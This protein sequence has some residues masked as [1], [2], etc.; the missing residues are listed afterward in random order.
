MLRNKQ[1]ENKSR[2]Q[3]NLAVRSWGQAKTMYERLTVQ[4]KSGALNGGD[5][6]PSEH[7]L[8]REYGVSRSTAHN[9]LSRLEREHMI[10]KVAGVGTF[11]GSPGLVGKSAGL[12]IVLSPFAGA[13]FCERI[14]CGFEE[15]AARSGFATLPVTYPQWKEMA[16]K[17]QLPHFAGIFDISVQNPG[18]SPL[19]KTNPAILGKVSKVQISHSRS[20]IAD[21]DTVYIDDLDGG[22]Q[23]AQHLIEAGHSR[24]AFLALHDDA[25][26]YDWSRRR[27]EGW[28]SALI[29]A[30]LPTEGGLFFQQGMPLGGFEVQKEVGYQASATLARAY[31]FTGV[32]A[33]D[34]AVAMGFIQRL[35]ES[36]RPP[37]DWPAIVSFDDSEIASRYGF[38][39]MNQPL[40][41]LGAEAALLLVER[42]S[43]R[44]KSP[45]VSRRINMRLINRATTTC[46]CYPLLGGLFGI[47][48][49]V[50][51][52]VPMVQSL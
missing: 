19:I 35:K 21:I 10:H 33:A 32:V 38:T 50:Q 9:V 27:A 16:R 15:Q 14:F 46:A 29:R 23:A 42:Y 47:K 6:L 26:G 40:E 2:I 12:L 1:T 28:E 30:G 3:R 45:S 20:T 37:D 18:E 41:A 7:A 24:I 44:L 43:G 34:D 49:E 36:G 52:G 22:R 8:A 17:G 5:T 51:Q 39:S 4:I 13:R 25:T 48:M 11:V 31:R